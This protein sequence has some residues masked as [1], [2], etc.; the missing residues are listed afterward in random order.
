MSIY[1][2]NQIKFTPIKILIKKLTIHSFRRPTFYGRSSEESVAKYEM[3]ASLGSFKQIRR[4][5]S[6]KI[7]SAGVKTKTPARF[8]VAQIKIPHLS[9]L[10]S[11]T[12]NI[13]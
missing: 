10:I 7:S 2:T 13:P 5:E 12:R 3:K 4:R 8:S 1:F 9:L 11:N 6:I